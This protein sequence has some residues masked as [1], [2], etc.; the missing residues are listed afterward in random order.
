VS[1]ARAVPGAMTIEGDA[2]DDASAPSRGRRERKRR[3]VRERLCAAALEL[4]VEHG[5]EATTMEQIGE[6]ADVARA[7]VFNYF[8][9][10]VGFL[11]EWGA[12]RRARVAELL[13]QQTALCPAP[14]H[15]RAYLRALAALNEGSRRESAVL[16]DA[17]AHFGRLFQDPSLE[18]DLARV[19]RAGQD[20]GTVEPAVDPRQA[21]SLLA[22]GYFSTVLQWA[23]AEPVPFDLGER[24]ESMLDLVL[25]ALQGPRYSAP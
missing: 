11:E 3:E 16:L 1:D 25:P 21:G 7:T 17:A 8:P 5:Y 14:E 22:A 9:Q 20:A 6:R 15:L 18:T 19:I 2:A 13:E 23:A 12:Q 24:L 10:K 4:F